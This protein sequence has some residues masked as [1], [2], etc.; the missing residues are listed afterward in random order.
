[1]TGFRELYDQHLAVINAMVDD[2]RKHEI[3]RPDCQAAPLCMGASAVMAMSRMIRMD[4]NYAPTT[5]M[6]AVGEISE[7]RKRLEAQRQC[8]AAETI[9]AEAAEAR[10]RD[11]EARCQGLQDDL[12]AYEACDDLLRPGMTV[13]DPEELP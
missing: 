10:V 6:V 8:T 11:L 13:A 5:I 1:M 3:G 2:R 4:P 12:D 7:T 9:R